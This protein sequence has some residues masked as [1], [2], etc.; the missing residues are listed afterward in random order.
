[1]DGKT[2][3]IHTEIYNKG[4]LK[5]V[6]DTYVGEG[7]WTHA[8]NAVNNSPSGDVGVLG[9]EPSNILCTRAPY[10]I[11]GT[12]YIGDGF[13]AIYSSNN[14]ASEI[15]LFHEETCEYNTIYN[16]PFNK[17]FNF[18]KDYP[19]IGVSKYNSD[20]SWQLYWDDG[21]NVSRTMNIGKQDSWPY[22][23]GNW[24]GVP[25][26]TTDILP[27]PCKDEVSTGTIDCDK[28]RLAAYAKT[29]CIQVKKGNGLGTLLN[30]SYQATI[31][32]SV[33]GVRVSDYLAISNV[34]ALWTHDNVNGSL[35]IFINGLDTE[36]D[37][38]ELV[39]IGFVNQQAVARRIGYYSTQTSTVSLDAVDPTLPTVPL[40]QIPLRTPAYEKSQG[41]Y[42][43]NEYLIR[44]APTTYEDFNYQPLANKIAT[45]WV[46]VEY[47]ADYYYKGG[48]KPTFLRD[49]V[50]SFFIRWIYD[51]GAKSSSYHIPGRAS[52]PGE[53]SNNA[54]LD[55][56]VNFGPEQ[57][58]QVN[59]TATKVPATGTTDDGGTIVFKGEMAYWQSTEKYPDNKPDV[60]DNLCG[61]EIRHHKFPD[62]IVISNYNTTNDTIISLGVEFS[63]IEFPKDS[64]GNPIRS[65][66]GYEILRGS[67]EANRSIIAKGLINNMRS[68][69]IIDSNITGLY[70]NY[71]YNFLDHD[72]FLGR[73]K[74]RLPKIR[75]TRGGTM[76]DDKYHTG[77]SAAVDVQLFD[78]VKRDI[79][80]FHSPETTFRNPFLSA[81][82]LKV[83][84][85]VWGDVEGRFRPVDNHPKDKF[86]TDVSAVIA[87][88]AGL[89]I[90]SA[91][92]VSTV[93]GGNAVEAATKVAMITG[94][95]ASFGAATGTSAGP[96]VGAIT[97]FLASFVGYAILFSYYYIESTQNIIEGIE[98]AGGKRQFAYQYVSHGFYRNFASSLI[99]NRRREIIKSLYIDPVIQDYDTS[100]RIN[101][102]FRAS[103]VSVSLN[104]PIAD[105]TVVDNTLFTIGQMA[106]G[107]NGRPAPSSYGL[108]DVTAP[109]E[110]QTVTARD[111]WRK[112]ESFTQSSVTSAHYAAL[113]V[114]N[115]NQY[116]QLD[117]IRQVPIGCI[118]LFPIKSTNP[119]SISAVIFGGDMY[120]NRYTEKSTFFYF[121]QWM[122]DLPDN[123][124]WDYRLYNMLPY[125]RYWMDTTKYNAADLLGGIFGGDQ[126][127]PNDFHHLDRRKVSGLF[128]VRFAY[129]YLFNSGIRDFYVESE[130]N[131]AY[132]DYGDD[133][134][135]RHYDFTTY[136]DYEEMFR[137]PYIKDTNYQ[138]Y[139]YALSISKHFS[140]FASWGNLQSRIYDPSNTSCYTTYDTRVIYSLQQQFELSK[141]NWRQFLANNYYDFDSKVV[142][143]RA[144]GRTG[145]IIMLSGE[146][147]IL[148]QGVETLDLNGGTKL[149][150]GDGQLFNAQPLQNLVNADP[151]FEYGSCQNR[152]SVINTPA[153]LFYMS[154]NQGKVFS[155]GQGLQDVSKSGMKWWFSQYSPY[156]LL[157]DFPDI[158]SN[159]LDNTIIGV[160]CQT[161][162]DNINEIVFFCK[163]DF[164]LKPQYKG[165]V[166]Y[167]F[168][169][170]FGHVDFPGYQFDLGDPTYFEDASWTVSYDPK[171][172]AFISFHDWHPNLVMSSKTYYMTVKDNG[173]WKHNLVCDSY[174]NYYGVNYPFEIEYVQNQGQTVT[175]TRSVEYILECY[176]YSPNCLDY[177]HLL[178]ENFDRAI[179][180]NTE[181]ISGDLRLN[182]SPKNNP[183]LI[184][185]YPL[186]NVNNIDILFSKEEQK[187]RFNQ[188]WDITND[189]GEFT[190]TFAPMWVTEANG[191]IRNINATY[192]NY[193]KGATQRKKFRHYINKV[194]L[195]KLVSGS[196]KFL[197]KLS[198][199]KLLASFR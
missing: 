3:L 122:Q 22:P 194:I 189:R 132:R 199:N 102:L 54:G 43:V 94:T 105:P 135:K 56:I 119:I 28:L 113:K 81:T 128:M 63:N 177:H 101:N 27:G 172:K 170:K 90:G 161:T 160:G 25:Y 53:L 198:N 30:G 186:V 192:V 168:S 77:N 14:F 184:N 139:D 146:S 72:S 37:E 47:P 64:A 58:W 167:L 104:S 73:D 7:Y 2:S 71:P 175:T 103:T 100:Y 35:D 20:C 148:F 187:Y 179:V 169:N 138:K 86:I 8:R 133:P 88:I 51:T 16:D 118:N 9:N 110:P 158:E 174:C 157:L 84:G 164:K 78:G 92:A 111:I 137:T 4:L 150:I 68:Y 34:Q 197:L 76:D 31:A 5:D 155:Y 89:G 106:R 49:E 195:K 130:I 125:P 185:N 61:L 23:V 13:W 131:L 52:K 50:Y 11:I 46:G 190:G 55:H 152:F 176:R 193:N 39:V 188:F 107:E 165:K 120:V 44:I 121:S 180:Y 75:Q 87:N 114:K 142:S 26:L 62:D 196:S 127:L 126:A 15:G 134:G 6:N 66:I 82:E 21:Y 183:Y 29:P 154:Q 151:E 173:I 19:V 57:N 70:V 38:F 91:A 115:D 17:C 141:D 45:S 24:Q 145:A 83:Y 123:T 159:I 93:L 149:S 166:I 181:Q 124:E 144:V 85:Q 60:W 41:M 59:N 69:D 97:G 48:N 18:F 95:F 79:F 143:M 112:P 33:N 140:N 12:V 129:M 153:G 117:N 42:N 10:T 162:Y 147:P 98:A 191:Y 65:I 99:G 178:D 116:G 74:K 96:I 80:S 108:N 156:A 163:R 67:R 136:T 109:A 182:L 171:A 1:M 40:E 36:Y 32:Y